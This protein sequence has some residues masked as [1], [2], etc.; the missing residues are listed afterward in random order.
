MCVGTVCTGKLYSLI[1]FV[2][3]LIVFGFYDFNG[4]LHVEMFVKEPFFS[5]KTLLDERW[6]YVGCLEHSLCVGWRNFF[7]SCAVVSVFCSGG[8]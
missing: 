2:L 1:V 7:S 4:F 3:S 8:K 5:A 6:E